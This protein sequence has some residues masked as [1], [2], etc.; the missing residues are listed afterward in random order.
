MDPIEIGRYRSDLALGM[1]AEWL[2]EDQEVT[3]VALDLQV[4]PQFRR[5]STWS[6][7]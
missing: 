4:K 3:A 6:Y 1:D 2:G 7:V 5:I